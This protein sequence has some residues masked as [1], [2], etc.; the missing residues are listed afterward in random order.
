MEGIYMNSAFYGNTHIPLVNKEQPL[1]VAS[2]GTYRLSTLP[3]LPTYRPKGRPDWQIIYIAKGKAHF[4][5]D[6]HTDEIVSAGHMVLFRPKEIQ[7]YVYYG[8]D[9]TEVFW[10]HFSGSSVKKILERYGFP[11]TGHVVYAGN[12]P[13]YYDLFRRIIGELQICRPN[14]ER[15]L[16][17]LFEEILIYMSRQQGIKGTLNPSTR[18]TMEEAAAYFTKHYQEDI[19]IEEYAEKLGISTCWFIRS[20]KQVNGMTPKQYIL[21]LRINSA[22]LL[23]DNTAYS[24]AE[25]ASVVGID[26]QLYFSRIFRKMTG[27]SPIQYRKRY[28]K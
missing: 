10:I 16:P 15:I 18:Q 26:N 12:I 8:V 9:Q 5:F 21:H 17:L 14:Y 27:T 6:G 4:Y 2:C 28:G 7:R 22:K 25:I 1:F 23:L 11:K 20:F 13:E 3:K 24:I 19:G